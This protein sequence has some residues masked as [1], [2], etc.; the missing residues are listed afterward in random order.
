MEKLKTRWGISSNWQ[1][2]IILLVF[3]ITGSS[4]VYLAK[5]VLDFLHIDRAQFSD[6]FWFGGF[7]YYSLRVLLIFP[8][9]QLLLVAYGWI[10][11]QFDFFWN[12]E[13]KMLKRMGFGKLI[14]N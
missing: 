8:I 12:F 9:Y 7:G 2:F 5:P 13:K 4:S 11:G 6:P 14:N 1:I 10:F 3:S